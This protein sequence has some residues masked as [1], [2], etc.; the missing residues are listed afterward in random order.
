VIHKTADQKKTSKSKTRILLC[1]ALSLS[2][3][4]F[5]AFSLT[6]VYK[7]NFILKANLATDTAPINTIK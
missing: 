2:A 5:V 7:L 6:L 4:P 1:H 3:D